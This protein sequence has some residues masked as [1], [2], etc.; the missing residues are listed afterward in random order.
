MDD[1]L[2]SI[3]NDVVSMTATVQK[4]IA[5]LCVEKVSEDEPQIKSQKNKKS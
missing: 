5:A 1:S 4:I 3:S 2:A